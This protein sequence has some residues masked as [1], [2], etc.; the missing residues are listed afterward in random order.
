MY[1]SDF[2]EFFGISDDL[3]TKIPGNLFFCELKEV[4]E[5]P[6]RDS[7]KLNPIILRDVDVKNVI[8][9]NLEDRFSAD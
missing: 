2:N 4:L 6:K 8:I 3:F 1:T 5:P 9:N 7:K